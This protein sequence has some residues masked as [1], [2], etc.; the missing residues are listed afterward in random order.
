MNP[1]KLDLALAKV[2]ENCPVCRTAR[3]RQKGAA[4]RLVKNIEQG[5]CPFCQAYERVHGKKAHEPVKL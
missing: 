4:Y 1:T 2:C 3:R 5:L